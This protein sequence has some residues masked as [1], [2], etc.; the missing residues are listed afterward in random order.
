MSRTDSA[1]RLI[2]ASA[3][4]LYQA[5]AQPGAMQRWLPPDGMSGEML[6]FDFRAGGSYRMRL[7][8]LAAQPGDAASEGKT[9]EGVD[10]VEVGLARL[11]PGRLIEQ[12][13]RFD[14][15]DPAFAGTMRMT[16]TFERAAAGTQVTVR[17]D[18]VPAGI[19]QAD[20]QAGM[21]D[22]LRKLAAYAEQAE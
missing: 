16:W 22:S 17:A 7:R 1:S 3:E 6:H 11:E 19:A 21:A 14:S 10:E 15:A 13:V 20:H 9:A 8:Y 2:H 12:E 4:R 18:D 5:F